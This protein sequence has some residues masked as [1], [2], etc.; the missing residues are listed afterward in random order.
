MKY[1]TKSFSSYKLA[2]Q[3][4]MIARRIFPDTYWYITNETGKWSVV[5]SYDFKKNYEK[6]I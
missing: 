6:I 3:A 1:Y 4:Q 5:E 2:R